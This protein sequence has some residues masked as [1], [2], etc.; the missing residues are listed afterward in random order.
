MR[1]WAVFLQSLEYFAGTIFLTTNRIECI[2]R[3]FESRIHVS[4]TYPELTHEWRRK[5]WKNFIQSLQID[6]S[7]MTDGEIG[8]LT[9]MELNGRQIKNVV[10]MASLLA[11]DDGGKL[12]PEDLETILRIGRSNKFAGDGSEKGKHGASFT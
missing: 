11:S 3:A 7:A 5:V 9:E 8:R 12:K 1:E 10:K 4:L 2:D 6:T